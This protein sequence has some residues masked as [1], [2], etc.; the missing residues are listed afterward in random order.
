MFSTSRY[1]PSNIKVEVECEEEEGQ[2]DQSRVV[3]YKTEPNEVLDGRVEFFTFD[4]SFQSSRKS[5]GKSRTKFFLD[6]FRK[7]IET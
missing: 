4:Q 1:Q 2:R 7:I 6:D 5:E 3:K